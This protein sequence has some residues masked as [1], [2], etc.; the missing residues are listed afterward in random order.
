M[1]F[2]LLHIAAF[3]AVMMMSVSCF[4]K[5]GEVIPRSTMSKIYADMLVTDQWI[6]ANP[7]VRRIA[8]TS[9]VYEPLLEKYGYDL[10]DYL[11]TV[12]RY[13]DDPERFSRI[14][15]ESVEI[16]E[17]RIDILEKEQERL[18]KAKEREQRIK[19]MTIESDFR[20]EEFFPY[21][22][23]E[24]YVH[25]Y[26]SLVV[27]IDSVIAHYRFRDMP[28][29]DTL[30]EGVRMMIKLDSLALSDSLALKDSLA[31]RDSLAVADSLFKADSI[32]EARL[33][34]AK[35][36]VVKREGMVS[37]DDTLVQ[38]EILF[39]N[40]PEKKKRDSKRKRR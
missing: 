39:D 35:A 14:F 22:F 18:Q 28:T 31:I 33:S 26:D 21:L 13:M 8:D 6:S 15:R 32:A 30:Y 23:D 2:F 34:A 12:D 11:A 36:A 40:P 19:D 7:D 27:E 3:F 25:Y 5:E 38:Q 4:K 29:T 16:I 20:P 1:R 10:D 17:K 24:P 9:L 37:A